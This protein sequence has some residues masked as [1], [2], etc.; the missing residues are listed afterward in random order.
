[1]LA[2][3]I[4]KD[5]VKSLGA[6]R[7]RQSPVVVNIEK[8]FIKGESNDVKTVRNNRC[9]VFSAIRGNSV[10]QKDQGKRF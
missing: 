8:I 7:N 10:E 2:K 5:D 9:L 4:R 3:L 1:M 6:M